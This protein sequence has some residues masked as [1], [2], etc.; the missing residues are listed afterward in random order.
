MPT[1]RETL[2]G[3][4]MTSRLV[5]HVD[6][7]LFLAR[8]IQASYPKCHEI[9]VIKIDEKTVSG[10]GSPEISPTFGAGLWVLDY[11][12]RAASQNVTRSYFHQGTQP[13]SKYVWWTSEGVTSPFYGAYLAATAMAGGSYIS[14]LDAG[15]SDFAGYVIYSAA[16]TPLRAILINSEY[17]DGTGDRPTQVFKL[18][19]LA[20]DIVNATRLTAPSAWSRQDQ[21]ES[22]TL[23][24]QSVSNQ[25]CQLQGEIIKETSPVIDSVASFTVAASEALLVDLDA[26]FMSPQL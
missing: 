21:G 22:P 3:I 7:T 5:E 25:T 6:L 23:G 18:R 10:E 15:T 17:Y 1:S 20:G 4:S 16:Q 9:P 19:G 13:G 12:L 11:A 8:R 26:G 24:G 14:A 2:G